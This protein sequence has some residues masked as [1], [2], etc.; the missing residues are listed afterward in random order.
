MSALTRLPAKMAIGGVNL[1]D[2]LLSLLALLLFALSPYPLGFAI[3]SLLLFHI[4]SH[5]F[6]IAEVLSNLKILLFCAEF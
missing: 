4:E 2:L 5:G 6:A 3:V 1:L